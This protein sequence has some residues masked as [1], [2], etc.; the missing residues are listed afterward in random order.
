MESVEK[1]KVGAEK[2][3]EMEMK[4]RDYKGGGGLNKKRSEKVS[5]KEQCQE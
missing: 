2:V 5:V 3:I 4:R 1:E